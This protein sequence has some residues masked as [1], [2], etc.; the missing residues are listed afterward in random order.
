MGL[1]NDIVNFVL[2]RKKEKDER[3]LA[4]ETYIEN[5]HK[6]IN[7]VWKKLDPEEK[8]YTL[9]YLELKGHNFAWFGLGVIFDSFDVDIMKMYKETP[10]KHPI[11]PNRKYIEN[12]ETGEIK[13]AIK[14][15][16]NKVLHIPISEVENY[17]KKKGIPVDEYFSSPLAQRGL[18]LLIEIGYQDMKRRSESVD[19]EYSKEEIRKSTLR[20]QQKIAQS[21]N[22]DRGEVALMNYAFYDLVRKK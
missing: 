10:L 4:I 5:L 13:F 19:R 12:L 15:N 8:L 17:I 18:E 14:V 1:I 3:V 6:F 7:Q 9:L 20:T 22:L 21:F 11:S 16:D 2:G